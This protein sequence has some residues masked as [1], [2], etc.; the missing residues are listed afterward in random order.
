MEK[1]E[2]LNLTKNNVMMMSLDIKNMYPS[3][4]VKL[5]KKALRFYSR[6]LSPED[7]QKIELGMKMIQFGMKN[8]LVSFCNKYFNYKGAAKGDDLTIKDVVLA[9]GG[10]ESAF[11]ADLVASYLLEM[12]GRKFI[13]AKYKAI[14][15][16]DGLTVLV[17]K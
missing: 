9:I 3:I 15:R 7:K 13:E 12:T 5:I 14:Y 2:S 6:S 8:T 16:D 1:L 17:G 4:Q 10:Y 11:L